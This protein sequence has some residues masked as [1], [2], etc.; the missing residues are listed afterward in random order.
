[1]EITRTSGS[2]I[3]LPYGDITSINLE[4]NDKRKYI[5]FFLDGSNKE[6][7]TGDNLLLKFSG[8]K[9]KDAGL[10]TDQNTADSIGIQIRYRNSYVISSSVSIP[11]KH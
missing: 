4:S 7:S 6:Y 10:I 11:F 5:G 8:L 3:E 9:T 1:M 2:S